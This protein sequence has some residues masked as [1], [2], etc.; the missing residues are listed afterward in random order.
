MKAAADRAR[1]EGARA[2]APSE[3]EGFVGRYDQFLAAGL[4]ANP[5]PAHRPRQHGRQKQSP[6]RNLLE[7][8]WLD[9][10]AVLAFLDDLT[11][12]F[13]NNHAGRDLRMPESPAENLRLFPLRPRGNCLQPYHTMS[14][15]RV[16]VCRF[17][18]PRGGCRSG[19]PFSN[20]ATRHRIN[21]GT[22]MT[23]PFSR[24]ALA[25]YW[26]TFLCTSI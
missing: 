4:A 20:C 15:H 14:H 6:A 8:L 3:R 24:Q 16:V 13:D 2:L 25:M 19:E 17:G 12:S 23:K 21:H 22:V 7:R 26:P 11:I 18:N 1:T 10:G 9:Q 5:P